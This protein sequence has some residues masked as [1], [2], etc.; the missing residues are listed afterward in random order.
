[1]R[2]GDLPHQLLERFLRLEAEGLDVVQVVEEVL[3]EAGPP[4]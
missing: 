3:A 1:M 2:E 4:R